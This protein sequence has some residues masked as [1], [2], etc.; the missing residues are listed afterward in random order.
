MFD[1]FLQSYEILEQQGIEN[2]LLETLQLFDLLSSGALSRVD[3]SVL[4]RE[5]I[6]L[7]QLAQKRKKGMPL[8]YVVGKAAFMGLTFF[9]SPDA[10]IPRLET[11][12]LVKTALNFINEK[13]IDGNGE[14][15][16]ID[17]GTGCGGIAVSLAVNTED[18]KVLAT[19][20]SPE[21]VE[22]AQKNVDKF[23]MQDRV[24]LFSGD[25][26]APFENLG[27]E[28]NIDIV[29]CNPPYIPTDSLPKLDLEIIDFE[30]RVALDAGAYGM[31][32]FRRLINEA[33]TILKPGGILVFEIG[34]GQEKLVTRLL[35]R[36]KGYENIQYFRDQEQA[37]RVISATRKAVE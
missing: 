21:A 17:M 14:L 36:H 34:K 29:V 7:I 2:P 28:S 22:L 27:Y 6:D 3:L 12:L 25:L 1:A 11:E 33:N 30:P 32:F 8:M 5:N 4:E 15:T 23:D 31:G 9:C 35:N 19:D 13:Q 37:I 20:I 24:Q 16:I 18:V 10:L 26:F